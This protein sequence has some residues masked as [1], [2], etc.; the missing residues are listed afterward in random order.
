MVILPL[1]IAGSIRNVVFETRYNMF[2]LLSTPS[3][4]SEIIA[5]EYHTDS[6]SFG[7]EKDQINIYGYKI[8]GNVQFG[9]I[10]FDAFPVYE[11]EYNDEDMDEA[12][13]WGIIGNRY[14]LNRTIIIDY[15]N[16]RFGVSR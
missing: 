8:K 13:V 14:F 16:R 7:F 9:P 6:L 11:T 2:P 5:T 15:K 10:V 4:V 12:G 1:K 3:K